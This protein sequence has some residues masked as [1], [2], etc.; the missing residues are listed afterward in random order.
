MLRLV[1]VFCGSSRWQQRINGMGIIA[2]HCLK[3][4]PC[5]FLPENT[6]LRNCSYLL[7]ESYFLMIPQHKIQIQCGTT[8]V[9]TLHCP[10]THF[11]YISQA[12]NP[13]KLHSISLMRKLPYIIVTL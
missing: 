6:E 3:V 2:H 11:R 5:S 13:E 7:P 12:A 4:T 8:E 1:C 10:E 9:M